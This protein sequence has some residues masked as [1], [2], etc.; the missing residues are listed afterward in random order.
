MK[1]WL[2]SRT[3]LPLAM[4]LL[5]APLWGQAEVRWRAQGVATVTG[6]AFVGVGVGPVGRVA[7]RIRLGLTLSAGAWNG[8]GAGR[9]EWA[10]AFALDARR[11]A[12]WVP[13]VAG[14]LAAT[15]DG[16]EVAEHMLVTAGVDARPGSRLGGFA[17]VGVAGGVRIAAGLRVGR[18][19]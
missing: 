14:G 6:R 12:R 9:V 7:R 8:A 10:V 16:E 11:R 1:S 2:R 13:Y 18:W 15:F 3:V 5:P 17:E 19:R 4:V